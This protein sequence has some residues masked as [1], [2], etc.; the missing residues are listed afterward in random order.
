MFTDRVVVA[1]VGLLFLLLGQTSVGAAE[2]ALRV[3]GVPDRLVLP[4]EE[5]VNRIITATIRG[6][7]AKSVWLAKTQDSRLRLNLSEVAPDQFQVNLADAD[8]LAVL[9]ASSSKKSLAA[10]LH[11]LD[12][13]A[14]RS[15]G[16]RHLGRAMV[17][18]LQDLGRPP[19]RSVDRSPLR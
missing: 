14:G 1:W 11:R 2:P 18:F 13:R 8:V 19:A 16:D 5:G 10:I 3:E 7:T 15:S 4:P 6:A 17:A 12:R 9:E